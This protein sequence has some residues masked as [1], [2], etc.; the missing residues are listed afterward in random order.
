MATKVK[1]A[2]DVEI[3]LRAKI[4]D[5]ETELLISSVSAYTKNPG[6]KGR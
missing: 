6:S 2:N 3:E 4:V 5:G 1:L